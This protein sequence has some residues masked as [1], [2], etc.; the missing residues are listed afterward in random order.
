MQGMDSQTFLCTVS[1]D[2]EVRDDDKGAGS[3]LLFVP[4]LIIIQVFEPD[5]IP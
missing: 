1:E 2:P 4:K 5:K 3:G